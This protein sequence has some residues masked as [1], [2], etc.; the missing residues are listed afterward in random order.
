ML[1]FKCVVAAQLILDVCIVSV[2]KTSSEKS[3]RLAR[4][5][6][7]HCTNSIQKLGNSIQK[8][9]NSIQKLGNSIQ[10]LGNSIQKLGNSFDFTAY[11]PV[12]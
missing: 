1:L 6:L 2:R 8:L 10:K 7:A 3:S 5:S 11:H 4:A 9:G 12:F